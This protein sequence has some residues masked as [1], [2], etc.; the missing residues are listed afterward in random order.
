MDHY[1]EEIS[2]VTKTSRFS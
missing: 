1:K 2:L